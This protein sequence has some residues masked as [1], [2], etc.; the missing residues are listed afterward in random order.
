MLSMYV[1]TI[2]KMKR[3]EALLTHHFIVG[4]E[5]STLSVVCVYSL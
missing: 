4:H 3:F 5:E 1:V 2:K